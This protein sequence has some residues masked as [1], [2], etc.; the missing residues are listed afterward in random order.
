MTQT[1]LL[2]LRIPVILIALTIHEYAHGYIA[3][4]KGDN[5]AKQAGRLTFNPIAHLD[6]LGTIMLFFGPFGWAKPVP[7]NPYN[8]DNP[9]RD[10]IYVGAAGPVSN[11]LLALVFGF[12]FRFLHSSGAVAS[13]SPMFLIFLQLCILINLGLSFFNLIPVPP[14][15]GS[16]ILMGFLPQDKVVSYLKYVRYAPQVFIFLIMT[17]W[18]YSRFHIGYPL[19]SFI[20]YP[21]FNLYFNF[22]QLIIFGGKVM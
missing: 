7:V 12:L 8:F 1:Q 5:T 10:M 14:L 9:K 3:W 20:I 2:I 13:L 18:I 22:W 4:R 15:D 17:D 11:I 21:I 19:F 6:V 16:N